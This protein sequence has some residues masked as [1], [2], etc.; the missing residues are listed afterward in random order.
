MNNKLPNSGLLYSNDSIMVTLKRCWKWTKDILFSFFIGAFVVSMVYFLF[1]FCLKSEIA[2][3]D[4]IILCIEAGSIFFF[5]SLV[6]SKIYDLDFLPILLEK[7]WGWTKTN[8]ITIVLVIVLVFIFLYSEE[9]I[10][11]SLFSFI[12]RIKNNSLG[13][14][15]MWGLWGLLSVTLIYY[16]KMNVINNTLS[17]GHSFF[18][19]IILFSLLS[20]CETRYPWGRIDTDEI[21]PI[22]GCEWAYVVWLFLFSMCFLIMPFFL[23]L[24]AIIDSKE[25]NKN[26]QHQDKKRKFLSDSPII[27][28]Q[29]DK[30][31][32]SFL[33]KGFKELIERIPISGTHSISITGGWGTGK[34]S[35][36]NLLQQELN[37]QNQYEVIWFY[38]MKSS[39]SDNIQNDFFNVLENALS[40]YKMGFGKRI[41][42]YKELIGAIDNKYISFLV[43]LW[44]IKLEE[45]KQRINDII[46]MVPKRIIIIIDDV[47][48]LK[49]DEIMQIFRLVG[50]NAEFDNVVFISALDKGNLVKALN[51]D[52]NYPDK[53]F[54]MEFPLPNNFSYTTSRFVKKTMCELLPDIPMDFL[55]DSKISEYTAYCINNIRDANRFINGIAGRIKMIYNKLDTYSY[56]LLHLIHYKDSSLYEK[57]K[58][59]DKN[60]IEI[61]VESD[62]PCLV[63][64][65]KGCSKLDD[66]MI[67][68]M[69]DLFSK[70]RK[71][72]TEHYIYQPEFFSDY[73][74]ETSSKVITEYR[75]KEL[76]L[77]SEEDLRLS[78][79]QYAKDV[80]SKQY[81]VEFWKSHN[82]QEFISS[83][84][85]EKESECLIANYYKVCS[86]FEMNTG[87]TYIAGVAQIK[88]NENKI[89]YIN[90]QGA[91]AF[92]FESSLSDEYNCVINHEKMG[93]AEKNGRLIV[94]CEYD[95]V[96][97]FS[98]GLALVKKDMKWGFVNDKGKIVIPCTYDYAE[99]FSE[100][101]A[102]VTINGKN[103]FIDTQGK[104]SIPCIYDIV[105]K[106]TGGRALVKKSKKWGYINRDGEFHKYPY[107]LYVLFGKVA[108]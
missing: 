20:Y 5:F 102:C 56:Y 10:V 35:F 103:G 86:Y 100:G 22:A 17:S 3:S 70:K 41:K 52:E 18:L 59:M 87:L 50:F 74:N 91:V 77:L 19:S 8:I 57:L 49:G 7:C 75:M 76:L 38:P 11:D 108:A 63:L 47:D 48:R 33:V 46:K 45:E 81:I 53:F 36:L 1:F 104:I 69:R 92:S 71:S 84:H 58:T 9:K 88:L 14:C 106:F 66:K 42:F 82:T 101:F 26:F 13:M 12:S 99:S 61:K 44:N 54:E 23:Y 37:A 68:L 31:N 67:L 34:T 93:I 39:K 24:R 21:N 89:I 2:T 51:C 95:A 96:S 62:K 25:Y 98:D 55:E 40:K 65:E 30:L 107:I 79:D 90:E 72:D 105:N 83:L 94:P 78:L 85:D 60:L 29:E 73:F 64:N 97:G 43:K 27:S 6:F 28:K 80:I 4:I 16:T 32:F 15:L